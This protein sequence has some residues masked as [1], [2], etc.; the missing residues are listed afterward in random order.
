MLGVTEYGYYKTF[1][2]Y[3]VYALLLHFGFPDGVLLIHAGQ[4]YE[5]ISKEKFRRNSRFFITFQILISFFIIGLSFIFCSGMDCYIFCMIGIDAFLVNVSTYYKFISQAV[6][7]FKELTIRNVIQAVL[8]I[9]SLILILILSKMNVVPA[10]G[11]VYIFSVIITDAVLVVWYMITYKDITFGQ[12]VV[13][14]E[15]RAEIGKYFSVGILLTVA[16]QVSHFVFV[17]DSQMV[18]V[19]FEIETYSLYAFAYSITNMISIVISAIATVMLPSLKR[20]EEQNAMSKF[21][22]L[23]GVISVIVFFLVTVYYP[24]VFFIKWYLPDY[25]GAL[26]YLKIVLPGL[27]VSSC[28]N[29]VI[30]TYYKVMNRLKRYLGISTVILFVG[31]GLNWAGYKMFHTPSAFSVASIL[32]LL[33]WYLLAEQYFVKTFKI[34]W[35]KNFLY[36]CMELIVFYVV[37]IWVEKE[38]KAMF[39]YFLCYLAVTLLFYGDEVKKYEHSIHSR[40]GRE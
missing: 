31:G 4:K 36:I 8:Q 17:L 26:I 10:N 12:A 25:T 28:I 38:W 5:D 34:K 29:W 2:L 22:D 16:F 1:T 23:M 19:L 39:L 40:K 32:T 27:A 6:M 15:Q 11:C 24:L 9:V 18:E 33:L 3:L 21:S 20:L 7:R 35:L 30:F 13:L 14:P 37:N